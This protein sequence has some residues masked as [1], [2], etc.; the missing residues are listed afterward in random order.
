MPRQPDEGVPARS[1]LEYW[2]L[3]ER[4][5]EATWDV[6]FF[7]P[8]TQHQEALERLHFL[9][10]ER[11]MNMGMLTGEI[12]CGKTLVREV[13]LNRLDDGG[14]ALCLIENSGFPF[15]D[16]LGAILRQM[17]LEKLGE[18]RSKMERCEAL[19][20]EA[21][22]LCEDGQHLTLVFDEAQEMSLETL[23]ELKLL[24]NLNGG[25]EGLLTVILMGQP[26]LRQRIASLP[27]INQ[28][29]SLRFHLGRLTEEE[30]S[31]YLRHRLR[32]AGHH[33]GELFTDDAVPEVYRASNGIPREVNRLAKMALELGWLKEFPA[34]TGTAVQA[35]VRDLKRHERLG[36]AA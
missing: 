33:N 17:G 19:K 22:G 6:R 14:H 3:D 12:G 11:T 8:S 29:I 28:R 5:F 1:L 16:L 2:H 7:F 15:E 30:A 9:V 25:G 35:V 32:M 4:P 18:R 20:A 21:E 31:A 23:N 13:L 27:A 10:S 24:T 34:I 36:E 26:D